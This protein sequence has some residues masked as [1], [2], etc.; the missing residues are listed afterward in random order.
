MLMRDP[1]VLV[2]NL[3]AACYDLDTD[4]VGMLE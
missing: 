1:K 3:D 4:P 2:M